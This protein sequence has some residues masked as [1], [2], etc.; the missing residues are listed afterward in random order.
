MKVGGTRGNVVPIVEKLSDRTGTA[1][2]LLKCLRTPKCTRLHDFAY[3]QSQKFSGVIPLDLYKRPMFEPICAWLVGVPIFPVLMK[4]PL[5]GRNCDDQ[6]NV[7]RQCD[8]IAIENSK[9]GE[10]ASSRMNLSG[11]MRC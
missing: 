4:R 1:F 2:R 6:P 9:N 3:I 10:T 11:Y 5:F 7:L 8:N